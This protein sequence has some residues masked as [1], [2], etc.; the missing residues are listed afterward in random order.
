MCFIRTPH[1]IDVP[2]LYKQ[3]KIMTF[4]LKSCVVIIIS[5]IIQSLA[6]SP[7]I[8]P[9][10]FQS[11]IQTGGKTT[12]T[13]AVERGDFPLEFSWRKDGKDIDKVE[14]IKISSHKEFSVIII[15]PVLSESGGNYTCNV[16]NYQGSDSY[17]AL[18]TIEGNRR[19]FTM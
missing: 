15:D 11:V 1:D 10:Y 13:C 4:I 19:N 8:Q 5:I 17:T 18:L 2:D 3:L 12:V 6:E 7:K 14:N 16:K 9:F